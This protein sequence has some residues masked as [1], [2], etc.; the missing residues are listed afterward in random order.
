MKI[1]LNAKFYKAFGGDDKIRGGLI[2][3]I[4]HQK[5]ILDLLQIPY[6]DNPDE[7]WDILVV[8][9]PWPASM[10]LVRKAKREGKK[11]V[12]WAHVSAEDLF[13]SVRIFQF[14]QFLKP[15][16]WRYLIRAYSKGDIVL[17]PSEYAKHTI[18]KRGVP[19]EKVTVQTNGIDTKVFY[20]DPVRRED[21]RKKFGMTGTVA[22]TVALLLPQR[23]GADTIV[24][25]GKAFPQVQFFWFGKIFSP[26]LVAPIENN[27]SNVRFTGFVDDVLAALNAIDIFVFPSREENQGIAILEAAAVGLPILV[28]NLPAYEGW[29][30]H[31]QNCLIAKTEEEFQLHFKRIL[32]DSA[33]RDK[34]IQGALALAQDQS[35]ESQTLKMKA[36]YEGLLGSAFEPTQHEERNS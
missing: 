18:V 35:L 5:K 20:K 12:I 34:L 14:L 16:V 30:I 24:A 36:I 17:V 13:Q 19:A 21:Y 1:C 26:A 27:T 9:I 7:T 28:R 22:G 31:E 29:L 23:K 33:L 8:N 10:A 3:A 4:E 32:E 25:L 2:A 11:V 6:T 15:L